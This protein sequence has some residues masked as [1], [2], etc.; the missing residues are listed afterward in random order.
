MKNKH[1]SKYGG[2]TLIEILVVVLIIG[3]LSAVALTGYRKAIVKSKLTKYASI[4]RPLKNTYEEWRLANGRNLMTADLPDF[5][6]NWLDNGKVLGLSHCTIGSSRLCYFHDGDRLQMNSWL[7]DSIYWYFPEIAGIS[8][9]GGTYIQV[10]F[11]T[12]QI[13]FSVQSPGFG[14]PAG[15]EYKLMCQAAESMGLFNTVCGK[16]I[17]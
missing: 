10:V 8:T 15:Q 17:K 7:P 2:F 3:I 13:N 9:G 11:K 12:N 1:T 16:I 14:G 4:I 6:D 5:Y